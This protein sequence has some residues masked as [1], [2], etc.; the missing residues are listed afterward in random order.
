MLLQE[1]PQGLLHSCNELQ[2]KQLALSTIVFNFINIP[3]QKISG[4][5]YVNINVYD[6]EKKKVGLI[7]A[8]AIIS[9]FDHFRQSKA[10]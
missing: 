3:K 4:R 2:R 6:Q 7:R 9:E 5:Q 10:M 8:Q 1:P